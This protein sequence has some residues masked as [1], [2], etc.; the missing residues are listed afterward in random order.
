MR[1]LKCFVAMAFDRHDT[2]HIYEKI[3]KPE[4]VAVPAACVRVDRIEHQKGIDAFIIE[5]I[6]QSDFCL[7]DLTYARPSV[8]YEAGFAERQLPV[9]YTCRS[10]H[11]SRNADEGLRVHFD[12]QMKPIV[13]WKDP[14]DSTFRKRLRRRVRFVTKP[15]LLGLRQENV[16]Q[17]ARERFG[18]LPVEKR[19]L[20]FEKLL[21]SAAKRAG[22]L[23]VETAPVRLRYGGGRRW[24]APIDYVGQMITRHTLQ[25][26]IGV[27]AM[28]PTVSALRNLGRSFYWP[29]YNLTA[30]RGNEQIKHVVEHYILCSQQRI[31][32]SRLMTIWEGF[33]YSPEAQQLVLDRYDN[34]VIPR[35]PPQG[36][37]GVFCTPAGKLVAVNRKPYEQFKSFT[38]DHGK[39][40]L[41]D[42]G[43]KLSVENVHRQIRVTVLANLSSEVE[44]ATRI[45]NAVE[46]TLPRAIN[47]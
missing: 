44:A 8:Y 18:H 25:V 46:S 41:S 12:L 19:L 29:A 40:W 3:I 13:K 22:F 39:T 26:L 10:D 37:D 27:T 43:A 24:E 47:R 23:P 20:I 32:L 34:Q 21:K 36:Y 14:N 38:C 9:V 17:L 6:Q 11:L 31:Q 33:S 15:L 30:K 2:D 5:Q 35:R 28:T 45:A 7:V 1:R 42:D 16:L 4:I